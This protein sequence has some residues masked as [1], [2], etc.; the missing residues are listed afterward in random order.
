MSKTFDIK[1]RKSWGSL[2]PTTRVHGD[3]TAGKKPKYG[4]NDRRNW[5]NEVSY[6]QLTTISP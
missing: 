1:I 5:K 6:S 2:N 3:K 4:K